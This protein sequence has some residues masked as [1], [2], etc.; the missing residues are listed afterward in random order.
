M[1]RAAWPVGL[2]F[3]LSVAVVILLAGPLL[4]FNPAFTSALQVRHDVAASFD[5]TQAEI[6]RVTSSYLADIYLGGDFD[7]ALRRDEPLLDTD[8]RSH[9]SDVSRL[10]RLLAGIAIVALVLAAVTG[11][12]L[13]REPRRQGAIMLI[14][15]GSIGAVALLLAGAFAV[16]FEPAFL[17]LHEL[18]FPPGT[19]LFEPGSDLITLFP[20]GFWFD[21]ALAA[22]GL[23]VITALVVTFI[24][25]RRWRGSDRPLSPA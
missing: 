3:G 14:S 16:A 6:E 1:D 8:E 23:I 10:V 24:G 15:A 21:A 9:M 22:G 5:T 11:A 20:E 7:A 19:Y 17:L 18:L 25:F 12:L 4:L 13:R 2:A